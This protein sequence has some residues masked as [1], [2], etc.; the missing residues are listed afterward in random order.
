MSLKDIVKLHKE[1]QRRKSQY[2]RMLELFEREGSLT[3]LDLARI[4]F[5]YSARVG[6]LRKK[7]KIPPA[8]YVKPGVYLYVYKGQK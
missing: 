2:D 8:E 1:M 6:E 4:C 5:R 7:Y 3:N